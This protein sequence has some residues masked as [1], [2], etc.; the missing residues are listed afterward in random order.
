MLERDVILKL[1]HLLREN[2]NIVSIA[3]DIFFYHG[4]YSDFKYSDK[5]RG[6]LLDIITQEEGKEFIIS[7]E[8]LLKKLHLLLAENKN[9]TISTTELKILKEIFD[10]GFV[11]S[12]NIT[13]LAYACSNDMN[14]LLIELYKYENMTTNDD[15]KFKISRCIHKLEGDEFLSDKPTNLGIV[16][17]DIIQKFPDIKVDIELELLNYYIP[18]NAIKFLSYLD[19]IVFA[20][21]GRFCFKKYKDNSIEY[22]KNIFD[23]MEKLYVKDKTFDL[24]I[25]TGFIESFVNQFDNIPDIYNIIK[26]I[27]ENL[28]KYVFKYI[29]DKNEYICF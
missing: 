17:E 29:G 19:I 7:K 1:I 23:Y 27:P 16:L 11:S 13:G 20:V 15:I 26:I 14:D 8:E 25:T 22:V 6:I 28:K 9:S 24:S 4:V 10:T 3:N 18:L 5:F 12:N 21:I 2:K